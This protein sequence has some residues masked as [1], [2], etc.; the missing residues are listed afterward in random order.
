MT[1]PYEI[2]AA[3][4]TEG[5]PLSVGTGL[6]IDAI[7]D[8]TGYETLWIN[9]RTLWRNLYE[10]VETEHRVSLFNGNKPTDKAVT[11]F[12]ATL[13][14]EIGFIRSHLAATL[15]GVRF[16]Y[17]G[18]R[19]LPKKYPHAILKYPSTE[20]QIRYAEF[21]DRTLDVLLE[22]DTEQ[23]IEQDKGSEI[24]GEATSS[25]IMT[26][27]PTDL[28]SR[29]KFKKLR[30]LES[31]TGAVKSRSEWYTKL[32]DGKELKI[33][34]FNHFTIQI[35]GD[36][37]THFGRYPIKIRKALLELAVQYKWNP[38]TSEDR[39]RLSLSRMSDRYAAAQLL[40]VL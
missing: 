8:L 36:G 34:P 3:R 10:S 19:D 2:V 20:L 30:L 7:K 37:G 17:L 28:L 32:T 24:R 29:F 4:A 13:R 22:A 35:F 6:A 40:K 14:E 26:H 1:D 21:M 39:I 33:V 5:L 9:I 27:Y 31:H 38:T 25:L 15:G 12:A 11:A 18:Y 16:Y 23:Y